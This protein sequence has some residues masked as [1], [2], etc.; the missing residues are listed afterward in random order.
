MYCPII[1]LEG[2]RK[3]TKRRSEDSRSPVRDLN[4]GP[5]EYEA[6]VSATQQRRPVTIMELL[7]ILNVNKDIFTG[8]EALSSVCSGLSACLNACLYF[9]AMNSEQSQIS[10]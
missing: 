3:I 7:G 5:S 2:L 1:Y 4:P 10:I 6:V 8:V 9:D